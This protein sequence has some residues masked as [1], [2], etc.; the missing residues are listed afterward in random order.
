[1]RILIWITFVWLLFSCLSLNAATRLP[2]VA[3]SF[4]PADAGRLSK[5]VEDF[6]AKAAP[7]IAV[8]SNSRIVGIIAPHAGYQYSGQTAAMAFKC[9][10]GQKFDRIYVLGVDHHS[11]QPTVSIWKDGVFD[12][13]LG[14]V[15]VDASAASALLNESTGFVF[16]TLQHIQEHSIEVMLPFLIKVFG[17]R[18]AV[19]I[20]VGGSPENGTKLG[21]ELVRRIVDFNGRTLIIASSD[22]SHYHDVSTAKKL[23]EL[24]IQAVMELDGDKLLQAARS[25]KTELCGLNG[26]LAL[27]TVMKAANGKAT[28]L[29]RTDSSRSSG[30]VQRVVGYAAILC[31]SEGFRRSSSSNSSKEA[32]VVDY[33]KEALNA[34]R[35][36]LEAVLAGKDVPKIEFKDSRFKEPRGVFVTLKKHGDLRGCI[37]FIEAIKPL[38]EAIQEMAISAA[39]H[40]PRFDPVAKDELKEISVEI[41]I[42]SPMIPVD[43]FS[44]IQIG[45]DGLLLRLLPNSG[46]F[47]PQVAPEQGWDRDALL[48]NLCRKA[49]LPPGSH[50]APGAKLWRFTADVF[51]EK[52]QHLGN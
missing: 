46:V 50:K 35:K 39:I 1:M 9:L 23:D 20:S 25:E 15:P 37:G 44:E 42:L 33:Q 14:S 21:K 13:P 28:L 38:G 3:G 12:T 49:G 8:A 40:D 29:E 17:I 5:M 11:G 30:D 43:D 47:L 16:D 2:A 32:D 51:G 19:F 7:Q 26:V 10:V 24:G 18:P 31:Q 34:V 41:S 27:L 4:Y 22:W 6:L 45:R 52:E 48:N 36:T